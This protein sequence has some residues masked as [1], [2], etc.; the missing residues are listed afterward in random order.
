MPGGNGI[1]WD[2]SIAWPFCERYPT[3]IAGGVTPE[4]VAEVIR[5]ANP[6][7]IDVSS[8]VESSPGVKDIDKV[9]QLI[10]NVHQAII[11]RETA[12]P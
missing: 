12:N 8:G 4:N 10:E 11:R 9:K 3:L 5:L 2:W 6:D 1:A 7:G